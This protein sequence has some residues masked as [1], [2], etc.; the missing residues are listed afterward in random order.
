MAN[1]NELVRN[2]NNN[3]LPKIAIG[4]AITI[5]LWCVIKTGETWENHNQQEIKKE[6]LS[7]MRETGF[8]LTLGNNSNPSSEQAGS[9]VRI[10]KI[11]GNMEIEGEVVIAY[12]SLILTLNPEV[13]ENKSL[14]LISQIQGL[15][16][17]TQILSQSQ[18]S[19]INKTDIVIFLKSEAS[20]DFK[21][22]N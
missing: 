14:E 13:N 4:A 8:H 9:I 10:N 3:F 7:K 2:F 17:P 1:N 20:K 18:K 11:L 15:G 5:F 21:V 22:K 16:Y 6:M 19:K 12:E